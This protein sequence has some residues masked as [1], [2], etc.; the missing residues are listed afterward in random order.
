MEKVLWFAQITVEAVSSSFSPQ[1]S[2]R[3]NQDA[4][5]GI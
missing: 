5:T 2:P 1:T 3:A 4:Q